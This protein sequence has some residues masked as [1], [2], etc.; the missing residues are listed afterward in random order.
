M[1]ELLIAM[2]I[3]A[4]AILGMARLQAVALQNSQQAYWQ[5]YASE[6]VAS[7]AALIRANDFS[8]PNS[9]VNIW[10]SR[11]ASE[12]PGGQG[13][14]V[15]KGKRYEVTVSWL[16]RHRQANPGVLP[17]K[18]DVANDRDCVSMIIS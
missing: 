14:I 16:D 4:I 6:Q 2:F 18:S 15:P 5:S 1:L 17:C 12:L 7:M 8:S 9:Q 11:L 3:L 13:V 10:K